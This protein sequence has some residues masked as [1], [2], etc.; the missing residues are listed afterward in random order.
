MSTSGWPYLPPERLDDT[1][2]LA[3]LN[4][5]VQLQLRAESRQAAKPPGKSP[6]TERD[7]ASRDWIP[8]QTSKARRSL[9]GFKY[10]GLQ[11]PGDLVGKYASMDIS[12]TGQLARFFSKPKARQ[13]GAGRL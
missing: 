11:R 7:E 3:Y 9:T 5:P 12:M 2:F 1:M 10:P 4:D 8:R 13:A 6:A